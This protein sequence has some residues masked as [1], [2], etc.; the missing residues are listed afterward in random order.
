MS[1]CIYMCIFDADEKTAIENRRS[2]FT[3]AQTCY[4]LLHTACAALL[5]CRLITDVLSCTAASVVREHLL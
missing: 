4:R 5:P 2:V 3:T 1:V